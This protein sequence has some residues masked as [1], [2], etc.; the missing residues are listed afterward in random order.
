MLASLVDAA[1]V[2]GFHDISSS[3]LL[4][5]EE[6]ALAFA[7]LEVS[8]RNCFA[9]FMQ[10]DFTIFSKSMHLILTIIKAQDIELYSHLLSIP[11]F[12]PFFAVSWLITWFAHELSHLE[13]VARVFDVLLASPPI[14]SYYLC[15]TVSGLAAWHASCAL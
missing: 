2:Q 11:N 1:H 5:L 10:S 7:A 13:H 14:Y 9:D 6:P 15:A 12:E 3:F 4:I 8:V